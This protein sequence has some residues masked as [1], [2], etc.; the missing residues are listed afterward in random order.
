MEFNMKK[1]LV[2]ILG[3]FILT[4]LSSNNAYSQSLAELKKQ[5]AKIEKEIKYL[6][7]LIK[8]G[9]KHRSVSLGKLSALD[10]KIHVRGKLINNLEREINLNNNILKKNK[11][12]VER[13]KNNIEFLKK[14]YANVIYYSWKNRAPQNKLIFLFSSESFNQAFK[15][16][17][18]FKQY[19]DYTIKLADKI[20]KTNDSLLVVNKSLDKVIK[21]KSSLLKNH[22]DEKLVLFKEKQSYKGLLSKLQRQ[23]SKIRRKLQ[24]Q[25]KYQNRLAAEIR[26]IIASKNKRRKITTIDKQLAQNF[27]LNKG[28]LPWPTSSGYI[29]STYGLHA[30]PVSKRTKVRNDGIDITTKENCSCLS[31][32][33]GVVSEVFNFPGLNNIVMVRH[34]SY[35]TVYANLKEVFVRKGEKLKTGQPI[36]KIFTDPDDKKTVLKFQVWKESNKMNP[37]KWL[38]R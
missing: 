25:I 29:S 3:L 15:R 28:K 10:R 7:D 23:E 20:E 1:L 38:R 12:E 26:R 19:S 22:N 5:K 27:A 17:K 14:Q 11:S 13:L 33:K 21:E 36:G 18:Y 34:G 9:E 37:Q 35:L 31:V 6:N 2:F 4:M 30:H 16:L 8:K 32:F 24:K